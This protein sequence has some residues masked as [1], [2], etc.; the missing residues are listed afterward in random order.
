MPAHRW[1][2]LST[3]SGHFFVRF[4]WIYSAC[5]C[6]STYGLAPQQADAK[7][8]H[9]FN[10]ADS[11]STPLSSSTIVAQSNLCTMQVPKLIVPLTSKVFEKII[12]TSPKCHYKTKKTTNRFF[13]RFIV[14]LVRSRELESLALWLK[15]PTGQVTLIL[16][17]SS[18][19]RFFRKASWFFTV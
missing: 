10:A 13:Q 5:G 8:V 11:W 6:C 17:V 15:E 7:P 12:G 4:E 1:S 18:L 9:C 16:K 14:L 2:R 19:R 3:V